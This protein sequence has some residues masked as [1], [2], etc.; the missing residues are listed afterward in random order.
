LGLLSGFEPDI[1]SEPVGDVGLLVEVNSREQGGFIMRSMLSLGA[2]LAI[3]PLAMPG[4]TILNFDSVALSA[5]ACTDASAYLA[6]FGITFAPVTPGATSIICNAVGSAVTPSSGSNIFYVVP[7][8][9]NQNVSYD[10]LFGTPLV[11]LSFTR[12][13]V[14][15]LAGVPPWNAFAYDASNTLLSSVGE[16]FR[17]P[18]PTAQV[19]TLNGP[20]ITRLHVDAF[21]SIGTTFN[22]PPIDDFTMTTAPEANTCVL[23]GMALAGLGMR[24]LR[25]RCSNHSPRPFKS[26]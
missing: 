1:Q 15:P 12:T 4:A 20:G 21:N 11:G 2:I 14:N 7:P 9:T 13:T 23:L 3:A 8:V 10:L 19:F 17:F 16:G 24:R 6:S 22:H 25:P 26:I 5:G 18:G